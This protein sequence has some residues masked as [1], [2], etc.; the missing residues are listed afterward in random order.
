[1]RLHNVRYSATSALQAAFLA[2]FPQLADIGSRC[3]QPIRDA[4]RRGGFTATGEAKIIGNAIM[5]YMQQ[6]R[7][8]EGGPGPNLPV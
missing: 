8:A 5:G 2:W 6:R 1:M 4:I 3:Q 7:L